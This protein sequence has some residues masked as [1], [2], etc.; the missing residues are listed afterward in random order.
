M[1]APGPFPRSA[2]LFQSAPTLAPHLR[3]RRP[4]GRDKRKTAQQGQSAARTG[5]S[6]PSR[7]LPGAVCD[8]MPIDFATSPSYH[9]AP[10][11]Q[12]RAR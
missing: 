4:G 2:A 3:A 9:R 1:S 8:G 12:E 11:T 7:V 6:M 10:A 5:L